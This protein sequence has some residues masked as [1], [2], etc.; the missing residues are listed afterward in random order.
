VRLSSNSPDATLPSSVTVPP[1]SK[2]ATFTVKSAPVAV[3][4][5]AVITA[6]FGTVTETA[7]LTVEAAQFTGFTVAPDTFVG[8]STT[9]VTG[10]LTLNGPPPSAGATIK[11]SSSNP[12]VAS[13]PATAFIH[14]GNTTVSFPVKHSA[15]KSS[16][17][18]TITAT[19]GATI[20]TFRVEATS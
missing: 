7:S 5:N 6:K 1:G 19:Y 16:E 20:R 10:T 11:L 3:N 12:S 9:S 18:V 13:V 4:V 17:L 14:S 8:S 2:T 15:V